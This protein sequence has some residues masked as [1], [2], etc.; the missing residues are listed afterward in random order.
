[1]MR[2]GI[3]LV[4][5]MGIQ[6]SCSTNPEKIEKRISVLKSRLDSISISEDPDIDKAIPTLAELNSLQWKQI[7]R[8][9][10]W[11][12]QP[13]EEVLNALSKQFM[14][15]NYEEYEP[16]STHLYSRILDIWPNHIDQDNPMPVDWNMENV[17]KMERC[18]SDALGFEPQ[19]GESSDFVWTVSK[20]DVEIID[21]GSDI[22]LVKILIK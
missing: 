10:Y 7:K 14:L 19:P 5:V 13:Y 11:K 9:P 21:T 20:F 15:I 4:I 6:F 8:K 12:D 3:L 1:M 17:N 2:I 22:V 18:I 16:G